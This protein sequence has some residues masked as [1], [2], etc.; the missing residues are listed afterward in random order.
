MNRFIARLYAQAL[1]IIH[2]LFL[3]A[4]IL[5]TIY[6]FG[7]FDAP[8]L[9]GLQILLIYATAIGTWIVVFGFIT[10]IVVMSDALAEIKEQNRALVAYLGD[11]A[12]KMKEAPSE[13][14]PVDTSPRSN[15]PFIDSEHMRN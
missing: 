10:T 9:N 13:R 5:F 2:G 4:L 8:R 12:F 11:M 3:L 6:V 14:L 15:E 7:G 1:A